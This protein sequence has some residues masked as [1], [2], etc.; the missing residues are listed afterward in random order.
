M[1]E[2][3]AAPPR[4][5]RASQKPFAQALTHFARQQQPPPLTKEGK[6]AKYVPAGC[7]NAEPV[8]PH[9]SR[10]QFGNNAAGNDHRP[11]LPSPPPSTLQGEAT[12]GGSGRGETCAGA[13][14]PSASSVLVVLPCPHSSAGLQ[15][16]PQN[17]TGS[18][19]RAVEG[20]SG[21][22]QQTRRLSVLVARQKGGY[23]NS[24]LS[25][26]FFSCGKQGFQSNHFWLKAICFL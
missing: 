11:Q 16:H 4:S 21:Q 3:S 25:K 2:E 1:G 19:A 14:S 7:E 10:R 18:S 6:I 9:S 23:Y 17:E 26:L 24:V 20:C 15:K 8:A 13:A 22:R 5:P 12:L